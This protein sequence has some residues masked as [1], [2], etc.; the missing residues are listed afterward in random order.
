[1]PARLSNPTLLQPCRRFSDWWLG[2]I[3]SFSVL[4]LPEMVSNGQPRLT[5]FCILISLQRRPQ[6]ELSLYSPTAATSYACL[7]QCLQ[8]TI[9]VPSPLSLK[10]KLA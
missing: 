1:M 3:I 6:I 8:A 7:R 9:V 10:A 5:Q 4:L 2:V